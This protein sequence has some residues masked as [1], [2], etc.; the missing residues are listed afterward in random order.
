VIKLFNNENIK[1]I[2]FKLNRYKSK[3]KMKI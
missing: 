2:F 1:Q 3:M